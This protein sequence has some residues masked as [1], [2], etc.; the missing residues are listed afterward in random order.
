MPHQPE[1]PETPLGSEQQL[2]NLISFAVLMEPDFPIMVR[3]HLENYRVSPVARFNPGRVECCDIT[4]L[5]MVLYDLGD[6]RN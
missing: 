4:G 2:Q 1:N 3:K 5:R 6:R